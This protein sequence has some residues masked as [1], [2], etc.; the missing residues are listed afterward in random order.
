MVFLQELGEV[1]EDIVKGWWGREIGEKKYYADEWL[2]RKTCCGCSQLA[3][4]PANNGEALQVD[5]Q[6]EDPKKLTCDLSWA[7]EQ[8][9]LWRCR[10]RAGANLYFLIWERDET[11]IGWVR[12][13]QDR[14]TKKVG[15]RI[16]MAFFPEDHVHNWYRESWRKSILGSGMNDWRKSLYLG[17]VNTN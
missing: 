16:T 12:K 6:T 14:K 5:W 3:D 10:V 4:T 2:R 11:D 7:S 15:W 9:G 1:E 13:P 17:H 8:T